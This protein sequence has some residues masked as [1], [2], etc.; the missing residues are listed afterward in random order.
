MPDIKSPQ[1]LYLKGALMLLTG[2]LA[3][4]L[5]ISQN[6]SLQS[7]AL[8]M[9]AIWGFCRAYYFAFYVIEH[10]IDPGYRFAGLTDFLR[11]S[12][13]KR[14]SGCQRQKKH[15]SRFAPGLVETSRDGESETGLERANP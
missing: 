3:S 4:V 9:I 13:R 10:Y 15:P 14:E 1:L 2:I 6:P 11:Y 8:L 12:L 7:I 5:L